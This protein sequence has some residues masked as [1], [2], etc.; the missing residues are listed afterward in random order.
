VGGITEAMATV[1][2]IVTSR[3][4]GGPA[5]LLEWQEL[6]NGEWGAEIAWLQWDRTQWAGRRANVLAADISRVD[7]QNY[8]AVPRIRAAEMA[9]RAQAAGGLTLRCLRGL[10]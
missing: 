4:V 2:P 8:G 1:P 7:G 10:R 6:P 3:T 9:R 5:Y